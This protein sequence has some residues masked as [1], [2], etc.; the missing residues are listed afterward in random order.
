MRRMHRLAVLAVLLAAG[1]MLAGC[2]DFDPDKLDF[3][4]LSDKKKLPGERKELFPGGVPGVT[5]GVPPEYLKGN[6]QAT[7]TA[8][9]DETLPPASKVNPG[10]QDAS[11]AL[12][13]EAKTASVEPAEAPKPKPK[14]KPVTA[15]RTPAQVTI[16]PAAPGQPV[17][18]PSQPAQSPWPDSN[19][20]QAQ[21]PWPGSNQAN[22]ASPW[23][24]APPPGT[25]S[26]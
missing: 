26:R 5:Q 23:P 21:S 14:R 12:K 24:A 8:N 2:E 15:Q 11:A 13:P 18:V 3:F 10:D 7:D 16:Q 9:A 6:Q 4:H 19:A 1:P 25:F 17:A 22:T 20:Q